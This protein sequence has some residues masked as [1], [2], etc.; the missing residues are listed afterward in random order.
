[1]TTAQ[2]TS[3]PEWVNNSHSL[4]FPYSSSRSPNYRP[5]VYPVPAQ[6]RISPLLPDEQE[7]FLNF[8]TTFLVFTLQQVRLWGPLCLALSRCD[9]SFA[10]TYQAFHCHMGL[11][12]PVMGPF[13]PREPPPSRSSCVVYDGSVSI[14]I[15]YNSHVAYVICDEMRQSLPPSVGP[16]TDTALAPDARYHRS[17]SRL[18]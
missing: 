9:P 3:L 18:Q 16:W 15:I 10:H 12:H 13:Y 14:Y 17:N 7:F 11:F 5:T 4:L 1:M 8:L 6:A 2:C